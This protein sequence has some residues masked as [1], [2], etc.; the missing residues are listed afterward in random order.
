MKSWWDIVSNLLLSW[1]TCQSDWREEKLI[2]DSPIIRQFLRMCIRVPHVS[3]S[4]IYLGIDSRVVRACITWVTQIKP[5]TWCIESRIVKRLYITILQHH[6]YVQASWLQHLKA[7]ASILVSNTNL[8]STL[9][10]VGWTH[11]HVSHTI[12]MSMLFVHVE[13]SR[14]LWLRIPSHKVL[15]IFP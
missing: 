2:T 9:S 5:Q 11:A 15:W 10:T 7:N 1:N 8:S 13:G 14:E 3:L 6:T 4:C 12:E